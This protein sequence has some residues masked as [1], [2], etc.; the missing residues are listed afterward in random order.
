M[1][2]IIAR[3]CCSRY[4]ATS[5]PRLTVPTRLAFG[6]RTLSKNVSQNGE[7][8]EINRIGLVETPGEAMSNRIKLM[9][10]CF[11]AEVSVRTRQKIQSAKFAYEVQIFCPLMI[12]WSPSLSARVCSEARSEPAFGSE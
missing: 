7:R 11:F 4:F 10:S 1:P 3:S 6:T 2:E 8:P 5:Q 9:P 12:K